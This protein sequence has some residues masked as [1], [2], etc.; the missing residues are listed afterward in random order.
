MTFLL[1]CAYGRAG[2]SYHFLSVSAVPSA[3]DRPFLSAPQRLSFPTLFPF[4]RSRLLSVIT[5]LVNLMFVHVYVCVCVCVRRH[6]LVQIQPQFWQDLYI[7]EEGL[8]SDLVLP[9]M[10][11]A[12]KVPVENIFLPLLR[13]QRVFYCSGA[14]AVIDRHLCPEATSFATL[15]PEA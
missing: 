14:P 5:T 1:L 2:L 7:W 11:G 4:P 8:H 12:L 9:P 15:P 6:S 3:L 13:R 10:L